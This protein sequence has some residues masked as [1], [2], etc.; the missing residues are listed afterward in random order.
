MLHNK[1]GKQSKHNSK[2]NTTKE[3]SNP[4]KNKPPH[5][6]QGYRIKL[7]GVGTPKEYYSKSYVYD[8]FT[9]DDAMEAR[10]LFLTQYG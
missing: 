2:R 1:T 4:G 7:N 5:R 6:F 3:I 10:L 8:A 9:E